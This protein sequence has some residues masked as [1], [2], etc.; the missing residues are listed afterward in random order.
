VV[1]RHDALSEVVISTSIPRPAGADHERHNADLTILYGG[2]L[3][4]LERPSDTYFR[5]F[6]RLPQSLRRGQSHEIGVSVS[7]PAEQ[8]I[9]PRYALQPLRRCDEFD[10]RIRFGAG[11]RLA[12]VW[13]MVGIP[14]GMA[15]DY[16][17]ANAR[18]D[19][20]EDGE[21]HLNYQH[22]RAGLVYGARWEVES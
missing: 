7:I 19:I 15:D 10:L 20:G 21:I 8:P 14:R 4:R 12:G 2:S 18:V 11:K 5:V 3:A 16:T 6:V 22:L 17:A 13:N 9:N 1:A